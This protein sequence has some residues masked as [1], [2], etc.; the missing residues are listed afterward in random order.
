MTSFRIRHRYTI[1]LGIRFT[2][3]FASIGLCNLYYYEFFLVCIHYDNKMI[4]LFGLNMNPPCFVFL[5]ILVSSISFNIVFLL[6]VGIS[7]EPHGQ[8]TRNLKS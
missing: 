6:R 7:H 5:C 8:H 4:I 1:D 2:L 3:Y